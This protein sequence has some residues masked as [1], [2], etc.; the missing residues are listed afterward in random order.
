MCVSRPSREADQQA[1]P[2]VVNNRLAA[3]FPSL[4]D[5]GKACLDL[6]HI[7]VL[8]GKTISLIAGNDASP[9][10]AVDYHPRYCFCF[11]VVDSEDVVFLADAS[12]S[13]GSDFTSLLRVLL[14][15]SVVVLG[16][17]ACAGAGVSTVVVA[18]GV[19]VC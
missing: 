13:E 10:L 9:P 6:E 11:T 8:A 2:G 14:V 16:A 3:V 19:G 18:D 17:G 12:G 15:D 5:A 4:S 1:H 7:G